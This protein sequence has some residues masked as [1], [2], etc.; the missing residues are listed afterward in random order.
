MIPNYSWKTICGWT[1]HSGKVISHKMKETEMGNRGSKSEILQTQSP[2]RV[3]VKEQRVDG[4]WFLAQQARNLR[5]TLMGFERSY[6]INYPSKQFKFYSSTLPAYAAQSD[7]NVQLKP[8]WVTGFTDAEGAFTIVIDKVK[9]RKLGW[10]I[11]SKFQ[12]CLHVR[13]L[14]LLL[15]IQQIFW[16]IGSVSVSGDLAFYSVSSVIDLVNIIVPHSPR[17]PEAPSGQRF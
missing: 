9:K 10:R 17:E 16:G 7:K 8:Y 5:C 4:S 12:V 3:S 13:D 11:Q 2:K 15:K 14:P 6:Q 1:N